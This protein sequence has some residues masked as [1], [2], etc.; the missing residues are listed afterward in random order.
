MEQREQ[1]EQQFRRPPALTAVTFNSAGTNAVN[2]GGTVTA[3]R[4]IFD[5]R[6]GHAFVRQR[7][8]H[9]LRRRRDHDQQRGH[10]HADVQQQL[11]AS[12]IRRSSRTGA[13]D[14]S[15]STA[16]YSATAT[17]ESAC[18]VW[19]RRGQ[20]NGNISDGVGTI[21][22]FKAGD[23]TWTIS[24]NNSSPA[25]RTWH[26]QP[27]RQNNNALVR[28]RANDR[29]AERFAANAG[30]TSIGADSLELAGVAG[31]QGRRCN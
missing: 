27:A 19:Q 12:G 16:R 6:G 26:G 9:V 28:L 8:A 7:H 25:K 15:R 18:D 3:A 31:G 17:R 29:R 13:R 5:Q 14:R 23:G 21:A 30:N 20:L 2:L 4:I 11:P 1:L 10:Q 22:L 24:G